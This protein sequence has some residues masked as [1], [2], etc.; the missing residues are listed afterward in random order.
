MGAGRRSREAFGRPGHLAIA[1]DANLGVSYATNIGGPSAPTTTVALDLA[2]DY[3]VVT[4]LS[5]GGTLPFQYTSFSGP[6]NTYFG[7]GARMGMMYPSA[8]RSPFGCA[9]DSSSNIPR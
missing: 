7:V 6:Q 3:F 5:I 8:T 1:N 4:G 2:A 9:T